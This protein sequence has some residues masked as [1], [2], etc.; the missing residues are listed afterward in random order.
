MTATRNLTGRISQELPKKFP[1]KIL[2]ELPQE[3]L[4]VFMEVLLNSWYFPRGLLK[5]LPKTLFK[6]FSRELRK[7]MS[8][9]T[10]I[11]ILRHT[12]WSNC[13]NSYKMYQPPKETPK[14]VPGCTIVKYKMY[15]EI[16][17]WR[18]FCKNFW[19]NYHR[20]FEKKTLE[21]IPGR[22]TEE[23][24]QRKFSRSKFFSPGRTLEKI[25]KEL[26]NDYRQE[27]HRESSAF[28]GSHWK[29]EELTEKLVTLANQPTN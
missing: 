6:Y 3:L 24:S 11:L 15:F 13:S 5:E 4:K 2:E 23:I 19:I 18:N 17:S 7:K 14:G 28:E 27:I 26:S 9:G 8:R 25:L 12:S 10:A 20:T 21:E 16:K 22:R 1:L 29:L